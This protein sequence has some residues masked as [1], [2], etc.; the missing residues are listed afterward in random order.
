VARRF[1][2]S[3]SRVFT[4][5]QI[6]SFIHHTVNKAAVEFFTREHDNTTVA[7]LNK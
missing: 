3:T 7:A 5:R 4:S 1:G 6:V 2:W